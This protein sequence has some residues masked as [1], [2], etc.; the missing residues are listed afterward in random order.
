MAVLAMLLVELDMVMTTTIE[1]ATMMIRIV[2]RRK[3]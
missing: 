1:P 3:P 2:N